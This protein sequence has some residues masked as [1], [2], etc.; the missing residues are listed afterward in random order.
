MSIYFSS[1]GRSIGCLTGPAMVSIRSLGDG[2]VCR[3]RYGLEHLE[4]L[5]VVFMRQD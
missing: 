4:E 5:D 1:A 3:I 2:I